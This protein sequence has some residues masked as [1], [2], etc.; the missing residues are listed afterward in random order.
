MPIRFR[1]VY[2]NQLLGIS[3]RK[4]GTVVRCTTCQGQLIVPDAGAATEMAEEGDLP[5]APKPPVE[6]GRLFERDDFESLLE[7]MGANGGGAVATRPPAS[8]TP[9]RSERLPTASKSIKIGSLVLSRRH[10][11]IASL[12]LVLALGL[13]FAAGLWL[14]LALR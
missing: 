4:A 11:T 12:V 14:G 6:A 1:C 2:C 13:A 3:K 8:Y 10:L 7:P 5:A 9:A